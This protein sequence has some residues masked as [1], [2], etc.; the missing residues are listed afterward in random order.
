MRIAF[1]IHAAELFGGATQSLLNLIDG[2]RQHDVEL[3]VT[4]PMD[5]PLV[6]RLAERDIPTLVHDSHRW[7]GYYH[8]SSWRGR[9][10]EWLGR[11]RKAADNRRAARSIAS[12]LSE[13]RPDVVYSN[14]SVLPVGAFVARLLNRPHVWHLR[15]LGELH[16]PWRYDRGFVA[17]KRSIRRL[18]RVRIACSETVKTYFGVDVRDRSMEVIRHG[19][20]WS[21]NF[22][23]RRRHR[24]ELEIGPR[25]TTFVVVGSLAPTKGQ[26]S[27]IE[28]LGA[29]HQRGASA[30]LLL[31]GQGEPEYVAELQGLASELRVTDSVEFRGHVDPYPSLLEADCALNTSPWDAMPRTSI[32]AMSSALPIIAHCNGGASELVEDRVT[33]WTYDGTVGDLTAKMSVAVSAG[34]D[35]LREM[36]LSAWGV[37]YPQCTIEGCTERVLTTL[38]PLA[39]HSG[40][41]REHVT[42]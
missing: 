5:G 24:E 19:V 20:D 8:A 28:A 3:H 2:L 41:S 38:A 32:E 17:T 37:V 6:E 7:T 42:T 25:P 22:E 1:F 23:E 9:A 11:R 40:A 36:G 16:Y 35:R 21:R 29:I 30:R 18:S 34:R 39:R 12:T 15:D 31:L 10:R 14:T 26:A 13:W 33:G 27:A 4:L